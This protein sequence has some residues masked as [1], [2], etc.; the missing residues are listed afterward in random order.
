M[1]VLPAPGVARGHPDIDWHAVLMCVRIDL[2]E[3]LFSRP[4]SG[5][6]GWIQ[7]QDVDVVLA[8]WHSLFAGGT[9]FLKIIEHLHHR[10][11]FQ[12]LVRDLQ[13]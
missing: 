1:F 10:A 4:V 8:A 3:T 2:P 5:S 6:D 11:G 7:T 12:T 9:M 13:R